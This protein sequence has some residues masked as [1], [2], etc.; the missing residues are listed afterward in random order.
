MDISVILPVLNEYDNLRT[1]IPRIHDALDREKLSFEII[2]VDGGSIDGT[3]EAAAAF[4]ARVLP[5]AVPVS[6]ARWKPDLPR[7]RATMF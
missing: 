4:G 5:S 3:R 1:L 7:P 2:V 6:P